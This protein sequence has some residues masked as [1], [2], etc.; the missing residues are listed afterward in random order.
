MIVGLIKTFK[1][2]YNKSIVVLFVNP[3][4][5]DFEI[6]FGNLLYKYPSLRLPRRFHLYS[7]VVCKT[8]VQEYYFFKFQLV[9]QVV[10]GDAQ[11]T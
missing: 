1:K 4:F 2:F 10:E 8:S 3:I 6:K 5:T 9:N 11:V 7:V